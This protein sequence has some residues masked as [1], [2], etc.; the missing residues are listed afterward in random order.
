[1]YLALSKLNFCFC[2]ISIINLHY[3]Q[4]PFPSKKVVFNN[5]SRQFIKKLKQ[6]FVIEQDLT[7]YKINNNETWPGTVRI[8][9]F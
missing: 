2:L 5:S 4:I 8:K 9:L 7:T 1:M 6:F 3:K